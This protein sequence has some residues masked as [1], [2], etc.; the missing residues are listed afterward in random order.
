MKSAIEQSIKEKIK[1][2]AKERESTF[3]ELW[4]NLI[5]E[6]F[7]TRL[8]KS[9]FKEKFI[10]KGGSLLAKYIHLGRETQDLDF[11]IQKLSNT[12]HSLRTALQAIC[13][14]D[15]DDSFSFEVTKIKILD[16]SQLAYTGTEVSLQAL[17]GA[18]KTVIRMDLGFGDRV[19][20]IEH[21][22]DLTTTSKGPLFESRICLHCYPK[23]F[24]FAEKLET[25][26]FRGEG[27]TRMKDFQDLYS[28]IQQ[29]VLDSSLA[30]KAVELVFHHRKTSLKKLPASFGK[31]AFEI[32]EKNWGAYRKKIKLKKE[33]FKLPESIEEVVS[34]VNQWLEERAFF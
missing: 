30:K 22:I 33:I 10:L 20:P 12:E 27:N 8:A 9:P 25:I 3:A 14:V 34:I 21:S 4:R 18:T 19:E 26:V 23:E 7:L 11:L 1:V 6:R 29:D 5:L 16:H 32:M 28:L 15:A 31:D 17:F 13:N 2:L 24:I